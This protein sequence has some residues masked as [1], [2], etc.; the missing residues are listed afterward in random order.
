MTIA[1]A[2]QEHCI[3]SLARERVNSTNKRD[4]TQQYKGLLRVVDSP[5]DAT[6]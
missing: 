3:L 5:I 2:V 1:S 6:H 4:K